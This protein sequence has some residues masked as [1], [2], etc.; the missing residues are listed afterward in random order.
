MLIKYSLFSSYVR[1]DSY[2]RRAFGRDLKL[3]E[4]STLMEVPKFGLKV[5]GLWL[6]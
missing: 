4:N 5:F 2:Y 6:T 1:I 3:V